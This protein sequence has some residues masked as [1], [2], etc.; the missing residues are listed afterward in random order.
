MPSRPVPT[1]RSSSRSSKSADAPPVVGLTRVA[2]DPTAVAVAELGAAHGLRGQLRLWPYH[3]DAP[4][5][6]RGRRVL[7]ERDDAWL[8]ATIVAVAP[9]GR[10]MLLTLDGIT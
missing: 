3:G 4:S 7:L 2:P 8:E 9:H 1:A 6:E 5:L 10:G